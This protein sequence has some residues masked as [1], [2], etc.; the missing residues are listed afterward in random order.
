MKS[1]LK[2]DAAI[3]AALEKILSAAGSSL[4]AY[5]IPPILEKMRAEMKDIMIESYI[6]GSMDCYKV[7]KNYAN[8]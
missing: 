7:L 6:Q 8:D 1:T 3:D 5:S 2:I 4:S